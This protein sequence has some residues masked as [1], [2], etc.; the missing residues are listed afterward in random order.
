MKKKISA[1]LDDDLDASE[2]HSVLSG[3]N[4]HAE[5]R[6]TAHLYGLIGDALRGEG[7][8]ARD[9]SVSV[10]AQLD[11]EPTILVP[12]PWSHRWVRSA[13]A[14]AA[15]V[16]GVA[17]VTWLALPAQHAADAE[18]AK[19]PQKAVEPVLASSDGRDM[20]EYL[21]AHQ[22]YSAAAYMN[23]GTQHIRTVSAVSMAAAK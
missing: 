9:V 17:L 1:L 8:L 19:A 18:L 23:G 21:I 2:V 10:M 7:S 4:Q 15:S 11:G 3:L 22:A 14:L 13:M 12:R 6:E 5:M 20:Q 16:A